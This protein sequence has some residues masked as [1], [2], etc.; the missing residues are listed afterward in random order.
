MKPARVPQT[1][2]A[3]DCW[4]DLPWGELY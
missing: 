3:P 4:G 1:V 2:V